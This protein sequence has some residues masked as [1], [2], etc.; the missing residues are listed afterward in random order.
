MIPNAK[1]ASASKNAN[2]AKQS[3]ASSNKTSLTSIKSS[4]ISLTISKATILP[5]LPMDRQKTTQWIGTNLARKLSINFF[6]VKKVCPSENSA[7]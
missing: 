1:I 4:T 2:N 7:T 3:S 6:Y 5:I